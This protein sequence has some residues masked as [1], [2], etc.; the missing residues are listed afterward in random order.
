VKFAPAVGVPGL[1]G[2]PYKTIRLEWSSDLQLLRVRTC[3]RP[4]QCYT[5][6]AMGELQQMLNDISANPAWCATS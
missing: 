1:L 5:L 4:I 2:R 3:V 6:A